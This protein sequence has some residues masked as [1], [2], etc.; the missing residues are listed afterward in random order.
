M[1]ET[2]RFLRN[3]WYAGALSSEIEKPVGRELLGQRMVLFRTEGGKTAALS[4]VCPH[5]YAPLS[6][7]RVDGESIECGYH[8]LRFGVSGK[9]TLNPHGDGQIPSRAQVASW[10]CLERYGFVW[11]WPG[12]PARADPALVPPYPFNEDPGQFAVVYGYIDVAANYQLLVD[13]LLDLS[14]VEFLH[15]M[16]KQSGG[17][18]AHKTSLT[19]E[20]TTVIANRAKPNV[21]IQGLARLFWTSPSK[22][23]DARSNMRWMPPSSMIFDL[24]GTECG[25]PVEEGVCLPN[26]HLITPA[27][28]FRSHYFWSVARNR[29]IDDAA[30]S[31]R[32]QEV[33]Q[34]IF[35]TED[36]PMVEDQQRNLGP[37]EDILAQRPLMLEPD[38][39][40]VRAR[41]ILADLIRGETEVAS[42]AAAE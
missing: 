16:F 25:R 22:K 7:G 26:A 27:G 33:T 30:A 17:V 21:D 12:D 28:Q 23:F 39:P 41:M 37:V 40:A 38:G 42:A 36:I 20:G 15:P 11:V 24:G 1:T 6:R 18:G 32:L 31:R 34:R 3:A 13:N 8:G 19:V 2:R 4:D 35:T 5:R 14:H 29:Q 10:P 9:C